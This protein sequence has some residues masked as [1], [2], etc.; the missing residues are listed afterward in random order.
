MK[1]VISYR[2]FFTI[3][4]LVLSF[5]LIF[6]S[7]SSVNAASNQAVTPLNSEKVDPN[8]FEF[9]D[10]NGNIIDSS[11][12]EAYLTPNSNNNGIT[13]YA[14]IVSKTLTVT[15]QNYGSPVY[16]KTITVSRKSGKGFLTPWTG[17]LKRVKSYSADGG[18]GIIY[19][20]VFKGTVYAKIR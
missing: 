14:N 3:S 13:P 17:T 2:Q 12:F 15:K 4:I 5:L 1:K 16:G 19:Y 6:T 18:Y 10:E 20:A 11:E 9:S 7:F 8:D